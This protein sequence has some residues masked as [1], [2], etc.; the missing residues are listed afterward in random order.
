MALVGRRIKGLF[1]VVWNGEVIATYDN[2]SEQWFHIVYGYP[3]ESM[4]VAEASAKLSS[5][6]W[7]SMKS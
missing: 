5:D 3:A 4:K 1:A 7:S 6:L 2:P